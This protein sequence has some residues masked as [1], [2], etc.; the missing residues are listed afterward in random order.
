[1]KELVM[2]RNNLESVRKRH[3]NLNTL[4]IR[5]DNVMSMVEDVKGVEVAHDILQESSK[6]LYVSL[7]LFN[8]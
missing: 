7:Y 6:Q 4:R 1:M 3:D 5:I 2:N 8:C